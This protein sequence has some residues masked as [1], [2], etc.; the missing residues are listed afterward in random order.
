[1]TRRTWTEADM[2]RAKS[3]F[4]TTDWSLARI[5]REAKVPVPTIHKYAVRDDWVRPPGAGAETRT[6]AG[7]A[8][9]Q[10]AW[11]SGAASVL[12]ERRL[13]AL[14]L[15]HIRQAEA[16]TKTAMDLPTREREIGLVVD[17]T[18]ALSQLNARRPDRTAA[19]EQDQPTDDRP[20]SSAR[21]P[22]D[23]RHAFSELV[24]KWFR[25]GD[26]TPQ[27]LMAA[28]D[29]GVAKSPVDDARP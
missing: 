17:L 1:M 20:G 22:D 16:R 14:I 3:L 19:K 21:T 28:G 10:R 26:R 29:P 18:K 5:A 24:A 15:Q 4:E 2:A 8:E 6:P 11:R 9:A 13:R 27:G 23:M 25:G 12:I 7:L